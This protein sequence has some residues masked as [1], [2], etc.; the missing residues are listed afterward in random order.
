[1]P[2]GD[3]V[4]VLAS[5]QLGATPVPG[6]PGLTVP[7]TRAVVLGSGRADAQGELDVTIPVPRKIANRSAVTMAVDLDRCRISDLVMISF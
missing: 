6:C 5:L 3:Q 7:L 4:L 1:M 2:P